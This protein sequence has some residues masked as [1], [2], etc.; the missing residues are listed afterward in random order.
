[1]ESSCRRFRT[2]LLNGHFSPA[3][4]IEVEDPKVIKVAYPLSSESHQVRVIKLCSVVGSFPWGKFIGFRKYF[5]PLFSAPIKNVDGIEAPLIRPSTSKYDNA[6][7]ALI[8]AHGAVG[9]VGWNVTTCLNFPPLHGNRIERPYII[10]V[11]RV[12]I[13]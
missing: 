3:E 2:I 9:T 6:V 5:H 8:V 7:I 4:S 1:M 11:V 13:I 12:C 10:H